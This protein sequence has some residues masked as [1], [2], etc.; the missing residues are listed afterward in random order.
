MLVY[1][2]CVK[3]L[4]II[5]VIVTAVSMARDGYA[6]H[7]L[8]GSL[9]EELGH[10][11]RVALVLSGGG[12]RGFAHIGALQILDSAAIPIDLIVGTI[13]GAIIGGYYAAG[14]STAELEKIA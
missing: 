3:R 13:M 11:P 7:Q 14:Y 8:R 4:F 6:Q 9:R 12:A 1:G 2:H 5:I 10:E